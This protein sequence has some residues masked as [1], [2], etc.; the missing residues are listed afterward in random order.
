MYLLLVAAAALGAAS[1]APLPCNGHP[2]LCGRAYDTVSY[3]TTHNAMSSS[4]ARFIAPNQMNGI[5]HQLDDGIRALML[6]VHDENGQV[7][8]CHGPCQ[9]GSMPLTVALTEIRDWLDENPREVVTFILENYVTPDQLAQSFTESGLLDYCH[10][11]PKG[12]PWPTLDSMIDSGRRLVVFTDDG[13]G[14]HTWLHP[15]W[16]YAWDTDWNIKQVE[17]FDCEPNRGKAGN[18]L[19]ILNHFITNPLPFRWT[20]RG[21]NAEE[22]LYTRARECAEARGQLPNFVTVDFY[23]E[24]D[25]L[26]VVD[27]L[28]GVD[29]GHGL[30]AFTMPVATMLPV[31]IE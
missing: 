4:E 7:L 30:A 28:N 10:R 21:A 8:L 27:Q 14:G 23:E 12:T 25:V 31:A 5:V 9:F 26:K 20:A 6:D 29:T 13:S 18:S 3:A 1:A 19:F 15:V 17:Q 22:V 16:D 2:D 11:Q 24:G